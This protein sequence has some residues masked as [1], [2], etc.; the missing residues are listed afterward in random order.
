M[1][2]DFEYLVSQGAVYLLGGGGWSIN[3]W[4]INTWDSTYVQSGLMEMLYRGMQGR[5]IVSRS[6]ISDTC[7]LLTAGHMITFCPSVVSSSS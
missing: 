3:T 1:F 4:D 7:S 5:T 6:N 2:I